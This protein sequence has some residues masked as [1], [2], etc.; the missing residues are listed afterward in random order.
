[1]LLY[2]S[3]NVQIVHAARPVDS[4]SAAGLAHRRNPT[5]PSRGTNC[6]PC[7]LPTPMI[8][9]HAPSGTLARVAMV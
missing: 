1:M 2:A 3:L 9:A 5:L 8:L 4:M 6:A 7:W